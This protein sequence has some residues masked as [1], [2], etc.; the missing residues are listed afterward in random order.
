MIKQTDIIKKIEASGLL[1]R[2]GAGYPVAKKWRQVKESLTGK[3]AGYIV[4][5]GA[6]GEPGVKKDGHILGLYP[7]LVLKGVKLALSYLSPTRVK[8]VYF[9]LSKEYHNRYSQGLKQC[10]AKPEFKGLSEKLEFV[11]KPSHPSYICGEETALLNL[12]EGQRL[13]ARL[14]PPY[15]TKSG[16][17]G[18]PTLVN[19]VETFYDVSLAVAGKYRQLRFYTISGAARH[20]G[21]YQLPIDSE[22]ESILRTTDNYPSF[23]FFVQVGGE[24]SGEILNAGQLDQPASGAGS[25]MVYDLKRTDKRKLL[26]RWFSFYA[27]ESCGQCTI[28]REGSYR[29]LEMADSSHFDQKL[30]EEIADVLAD[31]SLCALGASLPIPLRSYYENV[32][33][34]N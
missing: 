18:Q 26:R 19:N 29:L 24:A 32:L 16:L 21:V 17:F 2:G 15:P 10:L 4:V 8:R 5:N 28:C 1:G 14:K 7:E 25:I 34:N 11:V 3:K 27:Q 23:P 30:M 20:P 13:Q 31:S 9:V 6:E 12:I 33:K 22:I